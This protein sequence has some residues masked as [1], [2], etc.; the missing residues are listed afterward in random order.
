M[1]T[2]IKWIAIVIMVVALFW[3]MVASEENQLESANYQKCVTAMQEA[4]PD[5]N[6]DSRASFLK[7]CQN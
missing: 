2:S 5:P 1:E 7:E 3:S 6:D 4:I